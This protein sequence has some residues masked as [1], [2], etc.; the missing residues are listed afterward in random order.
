MAVTQLADYLL[1]DRSERKPVPVIVRLTSW[2]TDQNLLDWLAGEL[3]DRSL[4]PNRAVAKELLEPC[5]IL[6]ILPILPILDGLDE[7]DA[8]GAP[9]SESRAPEAMKRIN[10]DYQRTIGKPPLAVVCR[11]NGLGP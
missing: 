8:P 7:M 1:G 9:V 4:V 6:P 10:K 3:A 2:N 11:R 5:S